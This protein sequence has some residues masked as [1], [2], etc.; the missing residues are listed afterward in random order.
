VSFGIAAAA[1]ALDTGLG[2]VIAWV[3]VRYPFPGR[4]LVDA[5]IDL[6]FALPTAVAGIAPTSLGILATLIF[7]G[8][9]FPVRTLQPM[10]LDLEREVEE[11]GGDWHPDFPSR[12]PAAADSRH[13]DRRGSGL[14]PRR[15]RHG[16]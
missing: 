4:R 7:V 9:P 1:A 15:R 10:L 16:G 12:N 13:A 8:L 2:L 3:L 6:P 14:R 5:A 11:A